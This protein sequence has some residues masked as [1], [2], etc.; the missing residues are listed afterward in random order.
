MNKE[1]L[2]RIKINKK[3][4]ESG[5]RFFPTSDGIA[6]I[7]LELHMKIE[8]I[9]KEDLENID[10]NYTNK[11]DGFADYILKDE[12]NKP[13]VVLEAKRQQKNPLSAKEQAREYAETLGAR[14]IILSNGDLDYFWDLEDGDPEVITKYPTYESLKSLKALNIDV[15]CVKNLFIDEYYVATSQ[16]PSIVVNPLWKLNDRTQLFNYCMAND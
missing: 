14:Y 1:A 7:S 5:W 2:A 15:D 4:E 9:S 12:Y 13:I 3:L 11:R 6:N 10:E 16:E 8:N